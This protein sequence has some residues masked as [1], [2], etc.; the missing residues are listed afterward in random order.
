M[1]IFNVTGGGVRTGVYRNLWLAAGAFQ[2]R[3]T[4]GAEP[5]TVEYA[6]NDITIDKYLFDGATEEAIQAQVAFPD[7]WD[8]GNIK[9]KVY[10]GAPAGAS[11]DDGV[12]WGL[13]AGALG[14]NDA[15]DAALGTEQTVDDAVLAVGDLHTT[16]ATPGT[17]VGGTPQLGDMTLIQIARKV[18]DPNDDM[19]EDAELFGVMFQYKEAAAVG[20]AVW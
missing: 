14:D 5:V 16:D 13:R 11:V 18:S 15:I 2:P 3:E 9:A 19:T 4:N 8:K 10:W 17:T 12:T 1:P 6:T 20:P 7:E